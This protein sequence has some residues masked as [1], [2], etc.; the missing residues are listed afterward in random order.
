MQVNLVDVDFYYPNPAAPSTTC[1]EF[2]ST[3]VDKLGKLFKTAGVKSTGPT[4][5]SLDVIK[6]YV[7]LFELEEEVAHTSRSPTPEFLTGDA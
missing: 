5:Y 2:T 3:T 7:R 4:S 6:N 1:E